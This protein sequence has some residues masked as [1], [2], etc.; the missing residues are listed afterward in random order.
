MVSRD[1]R[2]SGFGG[3]ES[4]VGSSGSWVG[5][6]GS[7][8]WVSRWGRVCVHCVEVGAGVGALV[9]CAVDSCGVGALVR[10]SAWV[11]K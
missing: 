4:S 9:V 7:A 2:G 3:W 8:G 11:G 10:V 1:W 6:G 5:S